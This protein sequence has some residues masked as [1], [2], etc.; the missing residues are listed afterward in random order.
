MLRITHF[1]IIEPIL[2]AFYVSLKEGIIEATLAL[3]SL[4]LEQRVQSLRDLSENDHYMVAEKAGQVIGLAGLTVGIGR[5]RHS[6]S[7]FVYIA[8]AHQGQGI[9]TRLLQTLLDLACHWLT[10]P[11]FAL[12]GLTHE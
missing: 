3:P 11:R 10:L 7:V 2:T 4:R 1:I 5:L 8:A 12:T 9:G 6:G